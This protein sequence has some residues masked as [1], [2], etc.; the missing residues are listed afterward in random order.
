MVISVRQC[1]YVSDTHIIFVSSFL[2]FFKMAKAVRQ[3]YD[4]R[5]GVSLLVNVNICAHWGVIN[6]EVKKFIIQKISMQILAMPV[7]DRS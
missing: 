3:C 5:C 4:P 6:H 1:Y 2:S 7:N